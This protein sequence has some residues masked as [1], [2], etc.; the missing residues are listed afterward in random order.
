MMED[1]RVGDK[2]LLVAGSN[3]RCRKICRRM[4]LVSEDEE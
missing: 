3:K 2:E 4:R 1:G